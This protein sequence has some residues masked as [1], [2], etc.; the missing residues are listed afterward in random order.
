MC[1]CATSSQQNLDA[2]STMSSAASKHSKRLMSLLTSS[3]AASPRRNLLTR[4]FWI[5]VVSVFVMMSNFRH[6]ADLFTLI[7]APFAFQ[8]GTTRNHEFIQQKMCFVTAQFA[9]NV[10]ATDKLLSPVKQYR[11]LYEHAKFMVFTNLE[12]LQAPKGWNVVV[13]DYPQYNRSITKSRFPKFQGFHDD[14]IQENCRI[15]MYLDGS[16][17]IL[18]THE[19]FVMDAQRIL[20]SDVGLMQSLHPM[21]NNIVEEI[22]MIRYHGKDTVENMKVTQE[23]FQKQ[24]DFSNNIPVYQNMYFG[25][26]VNSLTFQRIA[27]YFWSVYSTEL[28]SWRDQPL[29]AYSLHHFNVTP[30]DFHRRSCDEPDKCRSPNLFQRNPKRE[31]MNGHTYAS[32]TKKKPPHLSSYRTPKNISR[33]SKKQWTKNGTTTVSG[34]TTAK[35]VSFQDRICRLRKEKNISLS[36]SFENKCIDLELNA[37]AAKT[38]QMQNVNYTTVL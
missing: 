2:P 20:D 32:K 31:G 25:Y 36:D 27:D 34:S 19:D 9:A 22:A 26:D 16:V 21:G 29:W 3:F 5:A 8:E 28:G 35:R 13:R 37:R 6:S 12:N 1:N 10:N 7:P 24:P 33:S 18:G 15:V 23:W 38:T 11:E 30:L 17:D 4:P 14:V